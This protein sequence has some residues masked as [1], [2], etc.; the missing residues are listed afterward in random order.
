M[1]MHGIKPELD[2][3]LRE[4]AADKG[5]SLN[6]TLQKLLASSLGLDSPRTD[7]RKDFLEFFGAWSDQDAVE[8]NAAVSEFGRV[9]PE[10]WQ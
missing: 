8:F 6:Q 3:R 1:T 10:E 7:H 9:D 2:R 4:E 5:L